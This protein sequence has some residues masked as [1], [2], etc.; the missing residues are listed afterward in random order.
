M[1]RTPMPRGTST[2]Q[3]KKPMSRGTAVLANKRT[4]KKPA[5]K[6]TMKTRQRAVTA[7]EQALWSR[8]A[9]LGCVACMKDGIFNNHVSIHHIDGRTKP[10]CHQLVLPLCAPH[11][12]QDDTD[13]MGRI[14][15]HG[16]RR[17]FEA[18][19]GTEL[20]LLALVRAALHI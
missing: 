13:P 12:Q 4:D 9:A 14:S 3:A 10:G 6:A 5:P 17:P 1:K 2:L 15:I 19:Y 18:R 16:H 11:H 7:A 20:E 8:M